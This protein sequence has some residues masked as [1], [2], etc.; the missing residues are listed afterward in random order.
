M[1]AVKDRFAGF[2][3]NARTFVVDPDSDLVAD[4]SRGDLDQATG[5]REAHRIVDD[6][7]DGAG[8]AVGLAHDHGAVHPR[9]GEGNARIAGF[10]PRLPAVH[11]LLD[12]WP[13]VDA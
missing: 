13:E 2:R 12:Q 10:A 9:A 5:R 6:G 7:I 3:G 11:Q 4:A 8:E 1:E